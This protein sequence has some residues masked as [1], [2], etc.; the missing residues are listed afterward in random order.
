M[1][2]WTFYARLIRGEFLVAVRLEYVQAARALGASDGRI[3]F[4]HLLVNTL[5]AAVIFAFADAVLNIMLATALTPD[6][7]DARSRPPPGPAGEICHP[8]ITS[9]L[10][11][12]FLSSWRFLMGTSCRRDCSWFRD[13]SSLYPRRCDR[14]TFR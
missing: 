1:A 3:V 12:G 13:I 7:D 2:G 6:Y 9:R 4:P 8:T 5:P 14:D 10:S 11:N